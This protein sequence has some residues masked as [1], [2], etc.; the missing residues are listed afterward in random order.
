MSEVQQTTTMTTQEAPQP[1]DSET[2]GQEVQDHV[3]SS[4]LAT[5][6]RFACTHCSFMTDVKEDAQQHV[7]DLHPDSSLYTCCLCNKAFGCSREEVIIHCQ[8]T[9]PH[10]H[11][12]FKK[13]PDFFDQEVIQASAAGDLRA[14]Q[15][16]DRGNI[17]DRMTSILGPAHEVTEDG[18]LSPQARHIRARDYLYILEGW[19]KKTSAEADST[20]NEDIEVPMD[21]AGDGEGVDSTSSLATHQ[22][23]M[24]PN[25][26]E[27][28]GSAARREDVSAKEPSLTPQPMS[29]ATAAG[30]EGSSKEAPLV[31]TEGDS[32]DVQPQ[33]DDEDDE[34]GNAD[35]LVINLEEDDD[36]LMLEA[37]ASPPSTPG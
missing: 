31:T 25:L 10:R 14:K 30:H 16:K 17:F 22:P 9:H 3:S 35:I 18:Q 8:D 24:T 4:P 23:S 26:E 2:P 6:R 15:G 34:D 20:T 13:L 37:T 5:L 7:K 29:L 28:S 11:S 32:T 27:A 36:G 19:C 33:D 1:V 21:E 12:P